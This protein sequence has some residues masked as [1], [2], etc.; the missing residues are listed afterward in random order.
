MLSI[1]IAS[2]N[3]ISFLLSK[4]KR[5]DYRP[6]DGDNLQLLNTEACLSSVEFLRKIRDHIRLGLSGKN[7][8][9]VLAEIGISVHGMLLEHYKKFPVNAMGGLFLTA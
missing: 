9:G 4:Q 2:I 8:E 5:T 6:R 7:L 3:H 1:S